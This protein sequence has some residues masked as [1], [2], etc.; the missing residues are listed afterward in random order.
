MS[1][2]RV[3]R[4]PWGTA[5]CASCRSGTWSPSWTGSSG[6]SPSMR[7]RRRR[8]HQAEISP[9]TRSG[10][11]NGLWWPRSGV[12]RA[13]SASSRCGPSSPPRGQGDRRGHQGRDPAHHRRPAT[14]FVDRREPEH[15]RR[16]RDVDGDVEPLEPARH[17]RLEHALGEVP[18]TEEPD[19]RLVAGRGSRPST[20]YQT[21]RPAV[22]SAV[23]HSAAST[24]LVR[25]S[26]SE[27]AVAPV[28]AAAPWPRRRGRRRWRR[29]RRRPGGTGARPTAGR[30]PRGHGRRTRR[31]RR[32]PARPGRRP[33]SRG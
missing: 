8:A 2:A 7:A 18:R 14:P 4:P 3:A 19:G 29:P 12:D 15:R 21:S 27:P 16:V 17:D 30:S 6:S 9:S 33:A 24:P 10:A 1:P 11:A 26:R 23:P 31:G 20:T 22:S 28:I 5:R 13:V 32:S 25:E